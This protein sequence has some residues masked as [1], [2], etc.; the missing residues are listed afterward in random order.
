M[1]DINRIKE[2]IALVP[3]VCLAHGEIDSDKPVV[4]ADDE[5]VFR[6]R[7]NSLGRA[8]ADLIVEGLPL[9][10]RFIDDCDEQRVVKAVTKAPVVSLSESIPSVSDSSSTEAF[11]RTRIE[12][13]LAMQPEFKAKATMMSKLV[14]AAVSPCF[15]V[16][17]AGAAPTSTTPLVSS[18]KESTQIDR[19]SAVS[20]FVAW[21]SDN[22]KF[23]LGDES[24][25]EE[26]FLKWE[27][28]QNVSS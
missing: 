27:D 9:L 26:A 16:E 13:I 5:P 4:L 7:T 14:Y 6:V 3:T 20:D 19:I 28:I 2:L 25:I 8:Y 23:P 21:L 11:V 17:N 10:A 1:T 24:T 12:A 15:S 18:A 22:V